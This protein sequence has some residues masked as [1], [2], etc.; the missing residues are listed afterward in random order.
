MMR[1]ELTPL[2][3]SDLLDIHR[4]LQA[5]NL[6]AADRFLQAVDHCFLELAAHPHAGRAWASTHPALAGVRLLPV[7]R[8]MNYLVFYRPSNR[9]IL[10]LRILHAAREWNNLLHGLQ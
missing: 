10:I 3:K 9:S 2:G 8:F 1:I 5:D 6:D 7:P 4:Y